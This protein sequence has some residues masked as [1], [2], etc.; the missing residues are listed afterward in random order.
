[1]VRWAVVLQQGLEGR[2]G[3]RSRTGMGLGGES[4]SSQTLFLPPGWPSVVGRRKRKLQHNA[5]GV[6]KGRHSE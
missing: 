3:A 1:M 2:A 5:M 4:Q 6:R